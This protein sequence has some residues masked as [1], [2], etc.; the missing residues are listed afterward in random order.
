VLKEPIKL[1]GKEGEVIGS[2][3]EVPKFFYM[4][5]VSMYIAKSIRML[6]DIT[7]FDPIYE[8]NKLPDILEAGID[9]VTNY[10]IIQPEDARQIGVLSAMVLDLYY[11]FTEDIEGLGTVSKNSYTVLEPSFLEAYL[12][13]VSEISESLEVNI[14]CLVSGDKGGYRYFIEETE[15]TP[16][17]MD[18]DVIKEEEKH[19]NDYQGMYM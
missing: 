6:K 4:G 8:K 15:G 1:Y 18:A 7:G 3:K 10:D 5:A 11:T 9:F 13:R 12:E 19:R 16:M 2:F 14:D 17:A